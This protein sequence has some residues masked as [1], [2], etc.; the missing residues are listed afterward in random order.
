V[1]EIDL[2]EQERAEFQKSVEA[3]KGL[4]ATMTQLMGNS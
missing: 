1:I 4:V 2:T 3:V